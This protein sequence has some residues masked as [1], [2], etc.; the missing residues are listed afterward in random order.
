MKDHKKYYEAVQKIDPHDEAAIRDALEDAGLYSKPSIFP[1]ATL[2]LELTEHCN[3]ACKHCYNNSGVSNDIPDA[4]TPEKWISFAKYL[5][6]HGGVFECIISG[7]EPLLLGD[8]MFEL[9]DVFHDDGTCFLLQTNGLL[10]NGEV[11][12]R[13]KKYQYHCLQISIDGVNA[14]YHDVFRQRI[15]CW[16][17]AVNGALLVSA[18]GIPLKI[19][20]C[21]TPYNLNGIDQ[22]C[23][24]AY[25]LGASA[26]TVGELCLSGRVAKHQDL[27]LSDK[28][29]EILFQKV[30]ENMSKYQGRMRVKSSNGIRFGLERQR[31]RPYTT[32]FIRP[33]G[34]IRIDGMAPF[35]I[36]NLLRDDFIETWAKKIESCWNDPQLLNFIAGFGTDDR[37]WSFI[38]FTQEDIKI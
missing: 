19:A 2:H 27:L 33:N 21:V 31:K 7:G 36:G 9:M 4:M 1:L 14:E 32:A 29:R 3:A 8:K 28:Q 34:D 22:M 25:S 10:L 17:R 30:K 26:I 20:H 15:G 35:V 37:N 5:V 11:V 18:A 6:A 12:Q 23:D 38:N 13:L 24:F 16:E